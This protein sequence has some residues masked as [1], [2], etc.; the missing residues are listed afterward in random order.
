MRK[1]ISFGSGLMVFTDSS[2]FSAASL[3]IEEP[4]LCPMCKYGIRPHQI[5]VHAYRAEGKGYLAVMYVCA[6]CNRPFIA[7]HVV[8][9][10]RIVEL[11]YLAPVNAGVREF[12]EDIRNLS[13]KFV[14]VYNQ[15]LA[16]ESYNL[17][18]IAGI[19]YRKALEF[20]IKDLA[21]RKNPGND[22]KIE[23]MHLSDCIREYIDQ[24]GLKATALGSA[25]LGND[26]AHYRQK[27]TDRDLN[28]LKRFLDNSLSWVE[29]VLG[30]EEA[31]ALLQNRR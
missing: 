2:A 5:Y 21:K 13:P 9:S 17:N 23:G 10:S 20:L 25:W 30:T 31:A 8:P 27:Y 4:S 29:L 1:E 28:D 7:C 22:E 11:E 19:G 24:P 14:E 3:E 6:H 16:A 15:A 18:E 26:Q 12:R